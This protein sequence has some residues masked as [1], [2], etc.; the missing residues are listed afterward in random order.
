M[1]YRDDRD[2]QIA[3][4]DAL[5]RELREAEQRLA[6][7]EAVE[8][9]RNETFEKEAVARRVR[10]S[11]IA[12]GLGAGILF[13]VM[14]PRLFPKHKPAQSWFQHVRPHC[15]SV[16]V[17]QAVHS[18]PASSKDK[19]YEAACWA[20]AGKIDE[21]RAVIDGMPANQRA[22]AAGVVFDIAHPIADAG[23]DRAAGPIM[24]LVLE[25]WPENYQAVYHAG[26]SE[27]ANGH[28]AK[29]RDLLTKFVGMYSVDDGFRRNALEVLARR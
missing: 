16:E 25:Y 27:Y 8:R 23:D 19:P 21:A 9:A 12:V 13:A 14:V 3:R 15:N 6:A 11:G 5:E 26:M 4:A 2:A 18:E 7:V 22:R 20:I 28:H 1:N 17:A 10:R 24:L 29:A